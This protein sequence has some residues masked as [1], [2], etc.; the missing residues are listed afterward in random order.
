GSQWTEHTAPLARPAAPQAPARPVAQP[1]AQVRTEDLVQVKRS[2]LV[3]I[4]PIVFVV[5]ALIGA[6]SAVALWSAGSFDSDP[7]ERTYA[8][9]ARAEASQDCAALVA[10]T[11]Q[12]FRDDLYDEPF[13]CETLEAGPPSERGGEPV[14]GIRMGPGGILVVKDE[15]TVGL[16]DSHED[17]SAY[18]AY[19]LIREDGNWKLDESD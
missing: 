10:V 9:F 19:T 5:A 8:E 17:V 6:L 15:G 4:L 14:W 1:R 3:W 18:T 2:K 7:L 12:S 13:T 11:T 16:D